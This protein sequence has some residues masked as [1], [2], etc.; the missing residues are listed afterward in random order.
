MRHYGLVQETDYILIQKIII[1]LPRYHFSKA[2]T[3]GKYFPVET[4]VDYGLLVLMGFISMISLLRLIDILN[5]TIICQV[6]LL[7]IIY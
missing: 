5:L 4:I 7:P 6:H 3:F 1:R 2:Y